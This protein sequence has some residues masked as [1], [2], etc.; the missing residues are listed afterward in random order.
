MFYT[1]RH[2]TEF[3]Y[4][5]PVREGV[6]EVRTQPR[7]EGHQ[8]CLTFDLSVTPP[9]RVMSYRDFLGNIVHHFDIPGAF[10][11]LAV[12]AQALVEVQPLPDL[13]TV[14]V[15][16]W[17][18]LDAQV[19]GGD[20]WDMLAPSRFAQP[21]PLL[22]ELARDVR[23]ERRDRPLEVLR[24]LNDAIAT[25]FE[26][27]PNS[28]KVDSPIDEAL[29]RRQGVCQDLAHIMIAMVRDLR[30]PCRYV[31]GYLSHRDESKPRSTDSATHAWVEAW[32]PG[33]GW[34][35]FDP[36]NR[37]VS[38]VH[39]VRVAVGRDYADVPPTRGIYKGNADEELR[40]AVR[41]SPADA[42]LPEELP[43]ASIVRRA[44]RVQPRAEPADQQQQ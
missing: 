28:T 1:V 29:R 35:G 23:A 39:H 18:D 17:K 31:S 11:E 9:T 38:G 44:R 4:S 24:E 7:S 21:T 36:T 33:P 30:I 10:S 13:E 15:G 37:L 14:S 3:R 26:Y 5:H 6:M 22:R 40:V 19:A 20:Y 34:I 2:R 27:M 32:L 42:P 12:T 8:R 43:P 25:T 41:V 16:D